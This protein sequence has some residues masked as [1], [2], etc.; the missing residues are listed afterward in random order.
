MPL[1]ET[2]GLE[3]GWKRRR[4]PAATQGRVAVGPGLIRPDLLDSF[5]HS[6]SDRGP[7]IEATGSYDLYRPAPGPL[8]REHITA[9]LETGIRAI[10]SLLPVGKGQRIGIFGGSGVGKST[11]LGS[12]S[13]NNAADVTVV[14]LIGER[15]ARSAR[16]SG[17]T[18]M[19]TE[20]MR[21]A[22]VRSWLLRPPGRH[23]AL[24]YGL[25]HLAGYCRILS[26][27]G[28]QRAAG[29]LDSVT[30]LAMAHSAR[31]ASRPAN[32][33]HRRDIHLRFSPCCPGF[34]NEAA[35]TF[36]RGSITGFFTSAG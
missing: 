13:R 8:D 35:A 17:A 24:R 32:R 34:L 25:L 29:P 10:D 26:R 7:Q 19:G 28:R 12:M 9:P 16:F 22:V 20:G 6:R 2:G 15:I 31:S 33:P 23:A 21:R 3:L 14:A 5:E 11:L 18:R 1:E 4:W 36:P 27:P 30:R